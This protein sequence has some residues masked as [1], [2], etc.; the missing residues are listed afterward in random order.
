[1]QTESFQ[2]YIGLGS[3]LGD[4]INI[5]LEAWKSI[6]EVAGVDCLK[7]SSPYQTAPVDMNSQHWFTNAVG[8]LAVN[9]TPLQLLEKMMEVEASFG[10]NRKD[11]SFGYQDRTLDLDMLYFADVVM[12][13]PELVLPHPR[14][15]SRLFVLVPLVE[16]APLQSDPVSG[17]AVSQMKSDLLNTMDKTAQKKQEIIKGSWT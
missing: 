16:I 6:G 15:G 14:I 3:N 2:V 12:N 5:L 8:Q 7:L 13:N 10:R 9:L 17:R 1:M 4:G 11:R